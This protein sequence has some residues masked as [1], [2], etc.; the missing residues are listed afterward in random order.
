MAVPVP[1]NNTQRIEQ[2]E[3]ELA[4]LRRELRSL[5]QLP[6]T[7]PAPPVWLARTRGEPGESESDPPIY[8][9][10]AANTFAVD[11]LDVDFD[12]EEPGQETGTVTARS[13]EVRAIAH[14]PLGGFVDLGHPCLAIKQRT[15]KV[16]LLPLAAIELDFVTNETISA[17][18]YGEATLW[19]AGVATDVVLAVHNAW[20]HTTTAGAV[21]IAANTEIRAKWNWRS[22]KFEVSSAACGPRPEEE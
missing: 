8:P 9:E 2:L 17:G 6:R 18:G 3:R 4:E 20:M 1:T 5:A 12:D 22:Q 13:A 16:L 10:V 11:Y 21:D 15:G 7:Q 14:H 19:S